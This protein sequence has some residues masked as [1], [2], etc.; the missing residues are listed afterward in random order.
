MN[1]LKYKG[2]NRYNEFLSAAKKIS[3]K[4]F[5]IDGIIGI[6]ATGGLS[7]GYCDDYSDLDLIIYADDKNFEEIKNYIAIGYLRYKNIELDT[8]V[9]SY[10]KALNQKSPSEYWSQTARW[11]KKNSQILFDTDNKIKNLLKE[12][13]I[14]PNWEQK[15]LLKEHRE[16]INEYSIYTFELWKKRGSLI[17]AKHSLIQALEHLIL[18]IYAKNKKFQPYTSKWL[19]YYLE[20]NLV[21]E[22]RY[23]NLI[24]KLYLSP[25]K[26][27]KQV[28]NVR[29]EIIKLSKKSGIKFDY[30][31]TKEFF[32]HD[33]KNWEKAPD[34]TKFYL[35]W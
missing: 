27:V 7:R 3:S 32:E 23:F 6:L 1:K 29:N 33:Q 14:F 26:N 15:D 25:V 12:K 30:E 21:P 16:Q 13:L 35:S 11:D 19:F 24:K 17:N 22:S 4:I 2:K 31:N 34:K 10:Q 28:K 8:L 9:E 5:K 20:N 18:W